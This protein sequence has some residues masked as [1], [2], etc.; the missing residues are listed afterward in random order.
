M[1]QHTGREGGQLSHFRSVGDNYI[2]S[3][4]KAFF[5]INLY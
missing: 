3:E 5:D 1:A 4:W 2:E